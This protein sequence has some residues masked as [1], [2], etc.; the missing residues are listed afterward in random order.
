MKLISYRRAGREG[1]GAVGDGGVVDLGA[2]IGGEFPTL[3]SAIA[4]LA[5]S[6]IEA[7]A[8]AD[9]DFGLDEVEFMFPI[10]APEK[11]LCIGRNYRGYHE[12][13]ADGGPEWPSVFPRFPSS[14]APHGE[15]ILT[16]RVSDELDFEGELC[17]V[18]GKA[19]RH[20][21]EDRAMD[22]VAGY[23]VMNEGS[24]RECSIA[25]P[26]TAPART[27]TA[28]ARS[29]PGWSP[30]TRWGISA[31]SGSRPGWTANRARTVRPP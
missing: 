29:A 8:G 21:P 20:I 27:F 3:Q 11:I 19:G 22:Y 6:R 5:L 26:R 25:A 23:T 2:R 1:Y 30:R 15:P 18:I 7:E 4:G 9:A 31:I 24:V 12:V 14:F 10:T 28:R 16:P 13:L 17:V